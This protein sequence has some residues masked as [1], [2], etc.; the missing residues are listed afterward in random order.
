MAIDDRSKEGGTWSHRSNTMGVRSI[1]LLESLFR[2]RLPVLRE[3]FPLPAERSTSA[4]PKAGGSR[5]ARSLCAN[6]PN[7]RQLSA[8]AM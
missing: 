3:G 7:S 6:H 2:R 1:S 5:G 4:P 8:A